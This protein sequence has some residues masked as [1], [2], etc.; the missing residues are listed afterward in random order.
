MLVREFESKI[1]EKSSCRVSDIRKL[2]QK[3][4]SL[5]AETF[6]GVCNRLA[7]MERR[8]KRF[9]NGVDSEMYSSSS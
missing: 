1:S 4:N 2:I 9:D 3:Q 5:M 7:D 8:V 6:D